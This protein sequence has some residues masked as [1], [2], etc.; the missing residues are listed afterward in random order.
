MVRRTFD[1]LERYKTYY[2]NKTDVLACK[3]NGSWIRYSSH[4]YIEKSNL[5][6][7]GLLALG[8]KPG[9]KI[10]MV[11]NNRPEWNFMD[12]GMAQVGVVNVP[13]YPTISQ[14]DYT[15]IFH[16]S[17][18]KI[19]IVSDKMLLE[20]L[21]PIAEKTS[22][23]EKIYTFNPIEGARN[24]LEI[25]ELGKENKERF[26]DDL[27]DIKCTIEPD[28]MTTLIYTSGTTGVPK[29]VMLSH[30]NLVSNF[31]ATSKKHDLG[32]EHRALSFLPICHIYE[33]SL[34]YHYQYKG[35]GVYYAENL[36]TILDNMKEVKPH[37]FVTVPRL[38]ERIYVGII[39][40][41]K[42]LS[43][44]KKILFFWAV[45]L[46]LKY[47]R[48]HK[49]GKFYDFKLKIAGKLIFSK[50]RE[51]LGGEVRYVVCGG[52]ALQP[53]LTRIFTAAGLELL[54]GYGLTETS[55]VIAVNDP[56]RNVVKIGT[57]GPILEDVTVKIAG[58]GEILCKGPNVMLGYYKAPDLTDEVVDSEGWFHTG[59][60]GVIEDGI[61][62]K[63]TDRKKEIF[64][65]SS[66]KYIAPQVIE[67]KFKESFFIEQI[68]VIGENE[69]FA[70]AVISP[71]FNFLHNWC[72]RH[73]VSFRDNSD[74]I[75][76]PVVLDRFQREVTQINK[77]LGQTEHIKRFRLITEEWSPLTGELSPT[78]KLKRKYIH[79][80]Y[81]SL[82][83]EIYSAKNGD[84]GD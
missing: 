59:D 44:F 11:S 61:F 16:H 15:H 40:K 41:G 17:E 18:P 66:G 39:G 9:D 82:I 49:N 81:K 63:I 37:L 71:N 30:A 29:G 35:I 10:A 20:R 56:A 6:S 8:F 79:D 14:D 3:Q 83:E 72:S 46:G 55:P 75:N 13:I 80:K 45:N 28:D 74:L 84:Y 43:F 51:A 33:R 77:T 1:L 64:K 36:G 65:L 34:N 60:V 31:I 76:N 2:P 27:E 42:D 19:L 47:E 53:R 54:E 5:V 68:I 70:S 22:S 78:L 67:N 50:W 24:W 38:L 23:I 52:A 62:L 26:I 48:D 7:Y 4:D 25:L 57:V 73:G 12:M 21:R 69:K 58:D 32:A